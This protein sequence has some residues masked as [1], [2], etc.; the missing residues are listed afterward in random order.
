MP[1][2]SIHSKIN[3]FSK[4]LTRPAVAKVKRLYK[5]GAFNVMYCC[6][7]CLSEIRRMSSRFGFEIE[8]EMFNRRST[9]E[10]KKDG[11]LR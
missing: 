10:L 11:V 4:I 8:E 3:P 5:G 6:E 7:E 1:D 9:D 2:C